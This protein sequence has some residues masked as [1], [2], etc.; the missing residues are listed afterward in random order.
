LKS[1]IST[2]KA[3]AAIGPYSQATVC[4]GGGLLFT[5]GQIALDPVSGEVVGDEI[6]QQ[7]RQ[8]LENLQSIIRTAGGSMSDVLKVTIYFKNLQ[9][10]PRLNEVYAAFFGDR[11]P[12]RSAVEVCRLPKDVLVEMDAVVALES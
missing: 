8:V 3:P 1:S 6:S 11:P 9:D 5:S 7:T 2:P 10:Y 4:K 12:A